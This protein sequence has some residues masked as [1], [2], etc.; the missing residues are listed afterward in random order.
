MCPVQTICDVANK[1]VPTMAPC[2]LVVDR[3]LSCPTPQRIVSYRSGVV[4]GIA[5][6][7]V[8]GFRMRIAASPLR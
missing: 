1:S 7:G 2:L 8:A 5:Y 4:Y 3:V 6:N